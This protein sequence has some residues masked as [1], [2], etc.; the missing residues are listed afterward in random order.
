MA[1]EELEY[2]VPFFTQTIEFEFWSRHAEE[3]MNDEKKVC[4][5]WNI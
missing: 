5:D 1:V 2:V 3:E 4:N